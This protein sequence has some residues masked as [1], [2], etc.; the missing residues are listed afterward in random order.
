MNISILLK[1]DEARIKK[2]FPG[3]KVINSSGKLNLIEGS[4]DITD[5]EGNWWDSFKIRLFVMPGYPYSIPVMFENGGKLEKSADRHFHEDNSCCVAME[6][7]LLHRCSSGLTITDFLQEFAVPYF[8][9]QIYYNI[10]GKYA[11]KEY[12][13]GFSGVRQF[14]EETLSVNN[15]A[16]AIMLLDALVTST[17]PGRNSSCIC[18][19]GKK[20]KNCHSKAA[21]YLQITGM[22]RILGDLQMF[23]AFN[24]L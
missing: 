4:L 16:T 21:I 19:S 9:N 11:D 24:N 17:L 8:A 5:D 23:K 7:T 12:A 22:Q 15:D 6:H 3:L 18:G 14:Y 13:H 1:Q 2:Y 10:N 20:F